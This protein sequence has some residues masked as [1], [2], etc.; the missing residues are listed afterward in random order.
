MFGWLLWRVR[1]GR[2][3]RMVAG[4]VGSTRGGSGHGLVMTCGTVAMR[5]EDSM[6]SLRETLSRAS[7]G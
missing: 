3:T 1:D 5:N 2:V 7:S 4:E 6:N